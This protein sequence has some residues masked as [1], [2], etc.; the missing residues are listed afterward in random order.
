MSKWIKCSE[1]LPDNFNDVIVAGK[2]LEG[3]M[4]SGFGYYLEFSE[5]WVSNETYLDE[6]TITHWMPL[7]EPPVE[8]S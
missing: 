7:P 6:A 2:S 8:E 5:C 1:R 3:E 4:I